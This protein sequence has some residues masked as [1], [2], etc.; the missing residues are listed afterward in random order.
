MLS[1]YL[2]K[3]QGKNVKFQRISKIENSRNGYKITTNKVTLSQ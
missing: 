2:E 1:Q 3:R